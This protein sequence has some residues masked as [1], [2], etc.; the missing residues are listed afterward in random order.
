VKWAG[1]V[2]LL[3]DPTLISRCGPLSAYP[4]QRK[5]PP[6]LVGIKGR[7]WQVHLPHFTLQYMHVY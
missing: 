5:G 2:H 4:E 1:E 3:F 6:D 7:P